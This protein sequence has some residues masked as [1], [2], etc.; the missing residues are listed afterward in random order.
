[1]KKLQNNIIFLHNLHKRISLEANS[2]L[3]NKIN[4]YFFEDQKIYLTNRKNY[5]D[6][7]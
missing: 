1:M 6:I 5:N 7:R 3:Y 2:K 4:E